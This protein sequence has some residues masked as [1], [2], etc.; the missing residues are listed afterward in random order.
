MERWS[1]ILGY[2]PV[3]IIEKPKQSNK[4]TKCCNCDSSVLITDKWSKCDNCN[5]Y[6]NEGTINRHRDN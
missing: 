5:Y 4:E 3:E 6:V 1:D 2:E